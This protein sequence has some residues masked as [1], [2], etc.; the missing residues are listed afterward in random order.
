[1]SGLKFRELQAS[2]ITADAIV[3]R[4]ETNNLV[5][6]NLDIKNLTLSAE[7]GGGSSTLSL[8]TS[9]TANY[10]LTLPSTNPT[11]SQ[12]LVSNDNAGTLAWQDILAGGSPLV[13][14]A[15]VLTVQK[16]Q[17]SNRYQTIN[18]A[19]TEIIT[20]NDASA[21]NPYLIHIHTG[22]YVEE[23]LILPTYTHICGDRGSVIIQPPNPSTTH[24]LQIPHV[25]S[26]VKGLT[27]RGTTATGKSGIYI[28]AQGLTLVQDVMIQNTS[29][30]ILHESINTTIE[31]DTLP[32][33]CGTELVNV[34]IWFTTE[35]ALK[36]EGGPTYNTTCNITNLFFGNVATPINIDVVGANAVLNMGA[37]MLLSPSNQPPTNIGMR[38]S[39]SAN[40]HVVASHFKG[41]STGILVVED[42]SASHIDVDGVDFEDC[43]N[44]LT[45]A[46]DTEGYYNGVVELSKIVIPPA[47]S[48]AFNLKGSRDVTVRTK[49][50]DFSTLK[51]AMVYVSAQTP[52]STT[53][54]NIKV[55]AGVFTED[56]PI[57]VPKYVVITGAGP[58]VTIVTAS[59]AGENL[60]ELSGASVNIF[61]IQLVG[62]TTG[63]TIHYDGDSSPVAGEIVFLNQVIISNGETNINLTNVNGPVAFQIN[64]GG[65]VG[66]SWITSNRYGVKIRQLSTDP[67]FGIFFYHESLFW[68][69]L[70]VTIPS[71][72]NP[73][74]VFDVTGLNGAPPVYI[75]S[76]V[77]WCQQFGA[78][79]DITV[80]DLENTTLD[81][82]NLYAIGVANLYRSKSSTLPVVIHAISALATNTSHD[83]ELLNNNTSGEIT[84]NG[85]NIAKVNVTSAPNHD[86]SFFL[87][88]DNT[89]G[90]T[91]TGS[92]N[93]GATVSNVTNYTPGLN[94]NISTG[95][96]TGGVLTVSSGRTIAVSAGTGYI[97]SG[98]Q[99][100]PV[101]YLTWDDLTITVDA[102][103]DS[104]VAV[105]STGTLTTSGSPPNGYASV[106]IGRV[107]TNATDVVFLNL[108]EADGQHKAVEIER[109]LR[110]GLGVI[111]RAGLIITAGTTGFQVSMTSGT[112]YYG[113][114]SY[115]PSGGTD[116]TFIPYYR[117]A[118]TWTAGTGVNSLTFNDAARYD[119]N[120]LTTIGA[121]TFVKHA[122]FVVNDGSNETYLFLYGQETF[123]TQV[124]AIDG[125][126]PAAPS[127]ISDNVVLVAGLIVSQ[128]NSTSWD[129]IQ[130]TRPTLAFTSAGVSAVADHSSLQNLS[131][132]THLQYLP[133]DGS[134][135]MTG[136]L[137][138][139]TQSI[140]N[141]GTINGVTITSLASRLAPGG[142]DALPT[143]TVQT[144]G[145]QNNE[146]SGV[147]FARGDHVHAHGVQTD[148]TMHAAATVSTNGF[149]SASD[150]TIFDN[151]TDS[152][153]AST[154]M[155]RDVSGATHVTH[156]NLDDGT[157]YFSSTG[158]TAP[159]EG[160][161]RHV[162]DAGVLRTQRY[163]NTSWVD[164]AILQF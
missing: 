106:V 148:G 64:I 39:N 116:I 126:M 5:T 90:T 38:L 95:I 77:L 102:N 20:R 10:N 133:V 160:D 161:W 66:A 115:A 23:N 44:N 29:I 121:N 50:G 53:Q 36:V 123:S 19:I 70:P 59:N 147:S 27:V 47:A 48:F 84:I 2:V 99:T 129:F 55:G 75:S 83:V 33:V 143:S 140:I 138:L 112:Y 149:M 42:G 71:V 37:C 15:N 131:A 98:T 80:F 11:V 73:F 134:R 58:S 97:T 137:N 76:T 139:N 65:I 69:N 60:L 68:Q 114:K 49:G 104:Y 158:A 122:L 145:T 51:D 43:T 4:I 25:G 6:E 109:A 81:S 107:R 127:F 8:P 22:I 28:S 136:S 61:K 142:A 40:A 111:V 26:S 150:K 24:V 105:N 154:L 79:G 120:D 152:S 35:N 85:S 96:L 153:T 159:Q 32:P 18:A 1:M 30:G 163:T 119:N 12:A 89:T 128:A 146:G 63:N 164:M 17:S 3:G 135:S 141:S 72:G 91:L 88:G 46:S 93:L 125:A 67:N 9:S 74:T 82:A 130:D 34:R 162:D 31:T 118:G 78:Q 124:E 45:V 52:T 110:A 21:S 156:L 132:D 56:N 54:W 57:I 94:A 117:I 101:Q 7:T 14:P 155:S 100:Q 13:N 144:I 41:F 87:R 108:I 113:A 103:S 151:A 157:M 62:S 92:L 86:V 16:N